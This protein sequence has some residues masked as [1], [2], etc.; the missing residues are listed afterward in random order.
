MAVKEKLISTLRSFRRPKQID[1][2]EYL[3]KLKS[4]GLAPDGR[5]V[6]D[7]VP[8]A[9]PIGYKKQPSMVEIVREMVRGERLKQAVL[10]AGHETFEEAE[11]FD[12]GDENAEEL[13]SGFENDFDPPLSEILSAGQTEQKRKAKNPPSDG[14][15][16][17]EKP[18]PKTPSP[19]LPPDPEPKK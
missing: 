8:L 16:A 2:E 14:P 10:E 18:A 6:P 19:D 1:L 7:P 15:G 9:P 4:R 13:R 12:V 5:Q 11:D 17:P 3:L